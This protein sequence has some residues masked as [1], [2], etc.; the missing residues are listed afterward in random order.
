MD[1]QEM[2]LINEIAGLFR[3]SRGMS[4]RDSL[5]KSVMLVAKHMGFT[6]SEIYLFNREENVLEPQT[7]HSK[8]KAV[9]ISDKENPFVEVFNSGR[10]K[11]IN[12]EPSKKLDPF[13]KND[14]ALVLPLT[15]EGARLGVIGLWQ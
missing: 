11:T 1:A 12:L 10:G 13:F 14:M 5:V 2:K 4:T 3:E 6:H 15:S 7:L 8:L 9:D